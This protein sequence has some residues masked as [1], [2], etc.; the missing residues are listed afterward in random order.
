MPV[1]GCM[2]RCRTD[3]H[4]LGTAIAVLHVRWYDIVDCGE[5]HGVGCPRGQLRASSS[6]RARQLQPVTIPRHL[7]NRCGHCC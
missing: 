3:G 7:Y 1:I 6:A 2:Q 5:V 4:H